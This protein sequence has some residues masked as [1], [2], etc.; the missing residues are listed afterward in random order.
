MKRIYKTTGMASASGYS[1]RMIRE[2]H[3]LLQR[4]SGGGADP[5]KREGR[6]SG[7]IRKP[8]QLLR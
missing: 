5:E 2:C 3:R 8:E 4:L 1:G 6:G 7:R